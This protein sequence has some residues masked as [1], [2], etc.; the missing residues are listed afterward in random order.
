MRI[1]LDDIDP[2]IAAATAERLEAPLQEF[3]K[4]DIHW[5]GLLPWRLQWQSRTGRLE[6]RRKR[7]PT[8]VERAAYTLRKKRDERMV[9][10]VL[11]P[12]L[13]ALV[14]SAG[15]FGVLD[16][17]GN[18]SLPGILLGI[19]VLIAGSGAGLWWSWKTTRADLRRNITPVEMRA[20]FPL[21]SL[22]RAER[23][24]C[25]ALQLLAELQVDASLEPNLRE[26]LTQMNALLQSHRQIE[27]QK[28]SLLSVMGLHSVSALESERNA[29]E[30]RLAQTTD[31]IAR[32]ALQQSLQ[33]CTN[34][35]ESA[36]ELERGL[37]R[38]NAQQEAIYH[39]LSS[40]V[41]AI[42]RLQAVPGAHAGVAAEEIGS[43]I[44]AINAQT[45]AVEQAVEEVVR[46]QQE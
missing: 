22:S 13:G 14:V 16:A 37:E 35:L 25:D 26:T 44:A 41:S 36:Q 33:M 19:V 38:L 18:L 24:Y 12:L 1:G 39:T 29:L 30:H 27:A 28:A 21:L 46:L 17:T 43:M 40:T 23:T 5:E 9:W 3:L 8:G 15:V 2:Q 42:A 31:P 4:E 20:V 7:E 45:R 10:R 6:L 32:Q 11:L 34:R